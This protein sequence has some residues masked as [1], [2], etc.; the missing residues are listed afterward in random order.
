MSRFVWRKHDPSIIG[1]GV[2]SL[3]QNR[4]RAR[5]LTRPLSDR[6]KMEIETIVIEML[7][8]GLQS[9]VLNVP[10]LA[11]SF[12]SFSQPPLLLRS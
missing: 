11:Q 5:P 4:R 8:V 12:L 2:F 6:E 9:E 10:S 1:L 7:H 3:I